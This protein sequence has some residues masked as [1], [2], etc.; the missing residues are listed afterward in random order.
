MCPWLSGNQRE[1]TG[2]GF[3]LAASAALGGCTR[4]ETLHGVEGSMSNVGSPQIPG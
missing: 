3:L 2:R 4:S 1:A